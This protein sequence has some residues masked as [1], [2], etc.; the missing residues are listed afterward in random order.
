MIEKSGDNTGFGLTKSNDSKHEVNSNFRNSSTTAQISTKLVG[1]VA[2]CLLMLQSLAFGQVTVSGAGAGNGSYTTLSAAFTAIGTTSGT[3]TI[4]ITGNTT[5]PA[6]GA[7]L[8][9]GTWTSLTISPSGGSWTISGAITAGSSLVTLNGADNV[10]INGLNTGGNALTFSNTTA[11]ATSGTSTFKFI[12]D[13]TNN[14]ITNCTILG[15][16]S[17]AVGTNG[18]NIFFST[19]TTTGNDNNTISN[20]N[21]GPAGSNLPTKAIFGNGSTTSTAIGN[22]G[23]TINNNNIYDFFGAAVTSSGVY[24]GGGCNAW[25]ITNNKFYQTATRTWTTGAQ[26]SPIWLTSTTALSG[27]QGFTVTGNIIGYSSN[28][29]TG[30][31]TL[32]GS[33]GKFVGIYFNGITGGTVSNINTNTI[34]SCQYDGCHIKWTQHE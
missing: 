13:A 6:G 24:T 27:A 5:E 7:S 20:C 3:I 31:Y 25:A 2:V 17:A 30:S 11:S 22:S 28:T 34:A 19:G 10:T 1:F 14:T 18:G 12:S 4:S 16:F 15:S 21:V 33:T 23:I 9:A 32:T 26:H 8:G 29:Q